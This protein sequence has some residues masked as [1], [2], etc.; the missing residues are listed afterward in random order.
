[1]PGFVNGFHEFL[2]FFIWSMIV[3][4]YDQNYT[5]TIENIN[6]ICMIKNI[7]NNKKRLKD[8][9]FIQNPT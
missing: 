7:Y 6:M 2:V 1:M 5:I 8:S 3:S 4:I 9:E